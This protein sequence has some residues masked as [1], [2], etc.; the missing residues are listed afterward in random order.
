MAAAAGGVGKG[1]CAAAPGCLSLRLL[2]MDRPYGPDWDLPG[3]ARC[4]VRGI[5][6]PAQGRLLQPDARSGLYTGCQKLLGPWIMHT[7][8]TMLVGCYVSDKNTRKEATG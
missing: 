8:R 2:H 5:Q 3:T 1:C 4:C 6:D 7:L